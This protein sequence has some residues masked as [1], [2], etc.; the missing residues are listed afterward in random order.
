VLS[1]EAVVLMTTDHLTAEQRAA[2]TFFLDGQGWGFGGSV[3]VERTELWNVPGRYGWIG[4]F[5]TAAYIDPVGHAITVLLTTVGLE[6]PAP[7][8]VMRDF[9]AHSAHVRS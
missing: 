4:G 7:P 5:G 8:A 9:W 1:P 2:S 6:S 3:D